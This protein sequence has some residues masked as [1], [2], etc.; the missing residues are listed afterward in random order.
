MPVSSDRLALE[1]WPWDLTA[2]FQT[3]PE[4]RRWWLALSGGCDS[5]FL[6]YCL[7]T[8]A[9]R[10]SITLHAIHLHHG[11]NSDADQWQRHCER[12]CEALRVPL[13]TEKLALDPEKPDLEARAR[14]ARYGCFESL[15]ES[16]DR[17]FMAHHADDQ[18]ETV[19]LRMLRGS[20]VRGLAGMPA[21]R[22]LGGGRLVRPL[23]GL[24][25]ARIEAL[26]G[27]WGLDWCEDSSNQDTR[28]DR[29]Y[30][31]HEVMPALERR[32]PRSGPRIARSAEHCR[33]ADRLLGELAEH[34]ARE[35]ASGT[36]V[37]VRAFAGLADARRQQLLRHLL[38]RHGYQ[39]P[40][41][42]RLTT[43]LEALL[44]APEDAQPEL[45]GEG[46][47]VCRYQ[48]RLWLVPDLPDPD[49]DAALQWRIDAGLDW[50]STWLTAEP[51]EGAG[52][53][54]FGGERFGVRVLAA[55]QRFR[56]GPDQPRRPLRK[57]L[58]EHHVPPWERAWLPLIFHGETLV[59]I[60]DLWIAPAWRVTV[61]ETGWQPVWH[62]PWQLLRAVP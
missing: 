18:A 51:R 54:T 3:L 41:E 9:S 16:G 27:D 8:L 58:Q 43:G 25:R 39:P 22:R 14:R 5:T 23:L 50:F 55:G 52:I 33:Q 28:F 4:S 15:L 38:I 10:H 11:L 37:S 7:S 1:N 57:W 45:R 24:E 46:Y 19:L 53:A 17:L 35:V 48:D 60:A 42:R 31:R 56:P 36:G 6:L 2:A 62:R 49:A 21:Q 44:K 12:V 61:G 29:N 30:L 59:A 20:G 47:R 32:W 40:G 26:A 13:V 34:D